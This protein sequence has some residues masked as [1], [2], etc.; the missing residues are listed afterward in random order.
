MDEVK[1]IE[2][3][4]T[5]NDEG[6]VA[7]RVRNGE[8]E[9]GSTGHDHVQKHGHTGQDHLQEDGLIDKDH[10]QECSPKVRSYVQ[11]DNSMGQHD[12][13]NHVHVDSSTK[14]LQKSESRMGDIDTT[15]P[16]ESVKAAVCMFSGI[17][18]WKARKTQIAER[19][20]QVAQ[21]LQKAHDEISVYS[22][23]SEEAEESKQQVLKE[24]DDAKRRVE[25]LKLN[26]E[27]AQTEESEAKQDAELANL[28]AEEMEQGITD[29]LSVAA[30]AQLEV[31]QARHQAAVSELETVKLE[32]KNLQKDYRLLV[33]ERDLATK[34]AEEAAFTCETTE[35]C[36]EDL[37]IKLITATEA[38]ESAQGDYLEAQEH[39]TGVDL[40]REQETSN[41]YDELQQLKEE[42]EMISQ[43]MVVT[44]DQ[45]S[46]LDTASVL[47]HDLKAELASYMGENHIEI[48]SKVDIAKTDLKET[49][50]NIKK[51]TDEV[52]NMKLYAN[53]LDSEL[54][55]AKAT[56]I[57]IKQNKW[58]EEVVIASLEAELMETISDV[59]C[60]QT[61]EN[62]AWLEEAAEQAN[63]AKS[64]ARKAHKE[65]KKA[66]KAAKEARKREHA[67]M[68]KLNTA[69]REVE[70]ARA[71]ERMAHGAIVAVE[72]SKSVRSNETEPESENITISVEEY[73]ELNRKAKEADDEAKDRVS[74]RF[75]R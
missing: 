30:K 67:V 51:T 58:T 74:E 49:K 16:F 68:N 39:R 3:D 35:K 15:A 46:K 5:T 62:A 55:Q 72:E 52:N 22:K 1:T 12:G 65:L 36:V 40:T 27:S 43:Q 28:R 9:D 18:D 38:L 7:N 23:R 14:Q 54:E 13:H 29:E 66:K 19:R 21:E 4:S 10:G 59:T 32:L 60:T 2:K 75:L 42:C 34:D 53:S 44:D 71:S 70:A 6:S 56:L 31:A 64:R 25:E 8:I 33:S 20:K 63:E 47:L 73:D 48:Q 17:V 37:T 11:E 24:L 57:A 26:L 41:R 45:K 61:K 69:A 50:L